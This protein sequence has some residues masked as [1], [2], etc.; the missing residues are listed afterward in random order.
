MKN[1]AL[2]ILN[3]REVPIFILILIISSVVGALNP[4]F[5]SIENIMDIVKANS[6]LLISS[7]GMLFILLTG[8][9]DVSVGSALAVNTMI[10]GYLLVNYSHNAVLLL[11]VNLMVG[12]G[13]SFVNG[14]FIV[15]YKIPAIVITLGMLSVLFGI[16]LYVSNGDWITGIPQ[17]FIAFG[18]YRFFDNT[19]GL[20]IQFILVTVSLFLAFIVLTYTTLGRSAY[21]LG[22]DIISAKRFGINTSRVLLFVY[23]CQGFL[24][25]IAAFTHTSIVGQADPNAFI[26]FELEVI[27]AAVIGGVSIHGGKGRVL[28]IVSGTL[29]IAIMNNGLTLGRIPTFWQKIL[30]GIVI[31]CSVTADQMQ[32]N[33]KK[34]HAP[35][36]DVDEGEL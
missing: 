28:N 34:N 17:S 24:Q 6:V 12:V 25:G 36:I 15:H 35:K 19:R 9:I 29:F 2:K 10:G 5:F 33:L 8:G 32:D 16:L 22:G 13:L 27:A 14:F 30:L 21:A 23:I 26:G 20:P 3:H 7:L 1:I 4:K 31:I 11:I 18:Q